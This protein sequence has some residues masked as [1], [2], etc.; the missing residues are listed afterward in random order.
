MGSQPHI[1]SDFAASRM[2]C[3]AS[4][5]YVLRGL[6]HV[7]V[8][9]PNHYRLRYQDGS[10][11]PV[12]AQ[13]SGLLHLNRFFEEA[14]TPNGVSAFAK[15]LH[16]PTC[17]GKHSTS[18]AEVDEQP[19]SST[20]LRASC[21]S[22]SVRPRRT[23]WFQPATSPTCRTLNASICTCISN[24]ESDIMQ[25]ALFSPRR[26]RQVPPRI[27]RVRTSS[28]VHLDAAFRMLRPALLSYP[29][30]ASPSAVAVDCEFVD[31]DPRQH[32][33]PPDLRLQSVLTVHRLYLL[34]SSPTR[35]NVPRP[36]GDEADRP[37]CS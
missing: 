2:A 5:D 31:I 30:V 6:F 35:R 29:R 37:L 34:S 33:P 10:V 32:A 25:N 4:R 3:A 15:A 14:C 8:V 28:A 17:P 21:V 1:L 26:R 11:R 18:A 9:T 27:A 13:P 20:E 24:A 22:T 12:D 36:S 19:A 7:A 23:A 16:P